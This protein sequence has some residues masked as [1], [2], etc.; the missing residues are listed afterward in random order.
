MY[1]GMMLI[2]YRFVDPLTLP[3]PVLPSPIGDSLAAPRSDQLKSS[4][5]AS[6]SLTKPIAQWEPCITT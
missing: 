3:E 6:H 2:F 4:I 5:S 1:H